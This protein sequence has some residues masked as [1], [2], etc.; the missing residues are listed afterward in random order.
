[1][2]DFPA[3]LEYSG[4]Y[5]YVF[6][7]QGNFSHDLTWTMNSYLNNPEV[8]GGAAWFGMG[9][10]SGSKLV[11]S[12]AVIRHLAYWWFLSSVEKSVTSICSHS[13]TSDLRDLVSLAPTCASCMV[14]RCARKP[15]SSRS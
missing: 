3:H 10:I 6:S 2:E 4:I 12:L 8:M 7:F 14:T 1:M 13:P 11:I 15:A 9:L 5:R